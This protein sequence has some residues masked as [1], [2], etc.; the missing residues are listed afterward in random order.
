MGALGT[1][2]AQQ[3][4]DRDCISGE[5]RSEPQAQRGK[6]AEQ[7]EACAQQQEKRRIEERQVTP[8]GIAVQRDLRQKVRHF[9]IGVRGMARQRQLSCSPEADEIAGY[10]E[11][12]GRGRLPLHPHHGEAQEGNQRQ[13][14]AEA[15]QDKLQ[16]RSAA[17]ACDPE[18]RRSVNV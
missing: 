9:A 16:A 12:A 6:I 18:R 10:F 17:G 8:A 5:G 1:A 11:N 4:A 3:R 15:E 13:Y 2:L 14:L 7:G